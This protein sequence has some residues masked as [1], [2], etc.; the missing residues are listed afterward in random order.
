MKK[1]LTSLSALL[2]AF[3]LA[4]LPAL[5]DTLR[6]NHVIGENT[7]VLESFLAKHPDISVEDTDLFL[8]TSQMAGQMLTH[9][10]L[11]DVFGYW[12]R[13]V[14]VQTL[15][16][17]GYLLDLSQSA[18]I[19]EAISRVY[20]PYADVLTDEGK[21]YGIPKD[22]M[23]I[24]EAVNKENWTAA[25]YTP[26]DVPHSFPEWLDFL[27]KWCD[28]IEAEPED[29]LCSFAVDY[30]SL[31]P[32][33]YIDILTQQLVSSVMMQAKHAGV[34]PNFRDPEIVAL[35]ERVQKTGTRLYQ[36]ERK[37]QIT[38]DRMGKGLF[39][40]CGSSK[41]PDDSRYVIS[42]RINDS[43]PELV[44]ASLGIISISSSTKHPEE[45]I[46]LLEMLLTDQ[47]PEY[48]P[49]QYR[50]SFVF[51]DGKPILDPNFDSGKA[52]FTQKV[53]ETEKKLE[54]PN[55]GEGDRIELEEQLENFRYYLGT[56]TEEKRYYVNQ[57]Q[58]D[59][60][61]ASMDR[62]YVATD[63]IFEE[64][65]PTYTNMWTLCR[66]FRDGEIS[67]WNLTG[68]LDRIVQMV[69]IEQQ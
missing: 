68:E 60:Y 2:A 21:I 5:A 31:K 8:N 49:V 34:N 29:E 55:L 61:A 69:L 27:E 24:Y 56:Y 50:N 44:D 40:P 11:P 37:P 9:E 22:V 46:Q 36:T 64:G 65:S 19:T 12:S 4:A 7:E 47:D 1:F 62:I 25:G 14:D 43:Q 58:L 20:G 30:D 17:K 63:G 53:Q 33:V 59:E 32:G 41:W 28:R 51:R 35:F 66:R 15:G 57:K 13:M 38:D 10:F 67:P 16:R 42:T 48:V 18:I 6:F 26:E 23:L 39:E 45:C 52:S 3:V 54:N